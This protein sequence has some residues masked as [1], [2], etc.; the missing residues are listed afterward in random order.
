MMAV[1]RFP[2]SPFIGGC[3]IALFMVLMA[4]HVGIISLLTT[5][6]RQLE[7][8]AVMPQMEKDA[9]MNICKQDRKIG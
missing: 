3:L 7:K 4:F 6:T 5:G 9:W 8:T 1:K 2:W